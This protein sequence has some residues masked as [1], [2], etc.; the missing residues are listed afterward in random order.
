MYGLSFNPDGMLLASADGESVTLWRIPGATRAGE[1]RANV[2]GYEVDRVSF[3]PDGTILAF[4]DEPNGGTPAEVILWDIKSRQPLPGK[5]RGQAFAFNPDGKTMA[6]DDADGPGILLRDVR[7]QKP[8]GPPLEGHPAQ[9][10]SI[11]FSRDGQI[12]AAGSK[13]GSVTIWDLLD[14]RS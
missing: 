2:R 10:S 4:S 5:I 12:L 7:T 11:A 8:L 13:D 6:V 9:V 1:L 14:R 3:S